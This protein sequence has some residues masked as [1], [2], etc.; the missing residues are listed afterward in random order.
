MFRTCFRTCFRM[1]SKTHSGIQSI[2]NKQN[3]LEELGIDL[4]ESYFLISKFY[5]IVTVAHAGIRVVI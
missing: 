4:V 1:C 2:Q 3:N 5:C